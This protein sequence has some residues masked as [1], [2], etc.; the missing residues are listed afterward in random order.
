MLSFLPSVKRGSGRNNSVL[1]SQGIR[2]LLC[3]ELTFFIE[4]KITPRNLT[5]LALI[6]FRCKEKPRVMLARDL[7]SSASAIGEPTATIFLLNIALRTNNVDRPEYIAPLTHLRTLASP[8]NSNVEA[9]VLLGKIYESQKEEE[10]ALQ[11]Y[12]QAASTSPSTERE[13]DPQLPLPSEEVAS[14][15]VHQ[16]LILQRRG[17]SS[18]AEAAFRQAALQHD[19]PTGYYHLARMQKAGSETQE[20]YFLKAASSGI[21]PASTGLGQLH[22]A[23]AKLEPAENKDQKATQAKLAKEWLYLGATAREDM[24]M[25]SLAEM[26]KDEGEIRSALKWLEMA[27][28]S[29]NQEVAQTARNM[30]ADLEKV[31]AS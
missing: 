23:K 2:G 15:L 13:V 14:A 8:P 7:L 18:G 5:L 22:L 29:P 1:V 28:D 19:D 21:M 4:E 25:L 12:R 3:S 16:G 30:R 17:N 31:T 9:I 24:S 26:F 10:K 27:E 11:L 20:T 6:L